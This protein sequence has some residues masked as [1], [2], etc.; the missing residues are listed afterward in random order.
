M[1]DLDYGPVVNLK[2]IVGNVDSKLLYIALLS[3]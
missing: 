1:K 2:T 3:V